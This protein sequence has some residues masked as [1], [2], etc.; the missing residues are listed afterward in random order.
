MSIGISLGLML[1]AIVT[2]FGVVLVSGLAGHPIDGQ[3]PSDWG[4]SLLMMGG[5]SLFAF[6]YAG[7]RRATGRP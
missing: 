2:G 7:W 5:A 3:L 4:W 6:G 1:S